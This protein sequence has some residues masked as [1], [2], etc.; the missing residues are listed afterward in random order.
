MSRKERKPYNINPSTS[1]ILVVS[2]ALI[3]LG[4]AI[5]QFGYSTGKANKQD[6]SLT[7]TTNSQTVISAPLPPEPDEVYSRSGQVTEIQDNAIIIT[8]KIRNGQVV[9]DA[10]L[11]AKLT[12]STLFI[13]LKKSPIPGQVPEEE[14]ET[15]ISEADINPGDTV[16]VISTTNIKNKTEFEAIEIRRIDRV[17]L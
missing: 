11:T 12:D 5:F 7:A 16:L 8:A 17:S 3:A 15:E 9:E 10:N 4:M 1:I 2:L 13:A 6:K 14:E